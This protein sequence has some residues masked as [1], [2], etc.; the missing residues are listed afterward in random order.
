MTWLR[1]FVNS[2]ATKPMESQLIGSHSSKVTPLSWAG[3]FGLGKGD[4]RTLGYH[5][6]KDERQVNSYSRDAQA[7][8]MRRLAVVEQA[9]RDDVFFPDETRSGYFRGKSAK[10]KRED[11]RYILAKLYSQLHKRKRDAEK[12]R[13]GRAK[14]VGLAFEVFVVPPL[15]TKSL[16]KHCFPSKLL[17]EV[18][19]VE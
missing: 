1:N 6:K 13:C 19:K 9:I 14:T 11:G 3:K 10:A 16:C 2:L 17:H 4:R 5:V 12:S 18:V 7:A 8:L 15:A